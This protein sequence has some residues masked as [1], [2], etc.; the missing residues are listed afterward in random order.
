MLMGNVS[1]ELAAAGAIP[2]ICS[3]FPRFENVGLSF[4]KGLIT[5][6]TMPVKAYLACKFGTPE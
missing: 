6:Q 1:K 2:G 4:S 5:G 3:S